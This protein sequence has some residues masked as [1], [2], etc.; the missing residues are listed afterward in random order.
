MP[1]DDQRAHPSPPELI[2]EHQAGRAGAN[3]ENVRIQRYQPRQLPFVQFSA[4][5]VGPE[6][7]AATAP[8]T[9]ATKLIAV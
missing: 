9:K 1:I 8:H 4:R 2:R 7:G 3:D 6:L 5:S